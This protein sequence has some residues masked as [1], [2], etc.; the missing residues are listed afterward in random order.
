MNWFA[1]QNPNR[2][3]ENDASDEETDEDSYS[4]PSYDNTEYDFYL[5]GPQTGPSSTNYR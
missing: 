2:D 3:P 4:D 5:Q 1:G